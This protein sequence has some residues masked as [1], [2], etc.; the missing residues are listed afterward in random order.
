MNEQLQRLASY[1]LACR[2]GN[3]LMARI[4]PSS[5]DDH[6]K[7]MLPGGK[8]EHGE[9]PRATVIR[10]FKEETGYDITVG[11]LL[12]FDAEHRLLTN[13][14]DLHAVFALYEVEITG[15]TLTP[16]GHGSVDTC[17]WHP[18]PTL[19]TLPILPPIREMLGRLLPESR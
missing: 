6:G 1:G 16:T 8:V 11:P 5:K 3:I 17:T 14:T 9:H 15:G 12:D 18:T 10:E 13:G 2:D 19:T 7:W 4:G